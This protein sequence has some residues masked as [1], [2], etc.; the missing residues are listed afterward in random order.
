MLE[1]SGGMFGLLRRL[2]NPPGG[3]EYRCNIRQWR[4]DMLMQ[5]GASCR[6]ITR[7]G[8]D[9]GC[10]RLWVLNGSCRGQSGS[11]GHD[12]SLFAFPGFCGSF[13]GSQTWGGYRTLSKSQ[14][15]STMKIYKNSEKRQMMCDSS[16]D[17]DNNSQR[18]S[19]LSRIV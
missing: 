8:L 7:F 5:G 16:Q 6:R 15:S 17:H 10:V 14:W 11:V 9:G 1:S 18:Y 19:S 12:W 4:R 3:S 2:P 13:E